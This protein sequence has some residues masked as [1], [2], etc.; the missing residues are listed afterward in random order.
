[1]R[2]FEK[3]IVFLLLLSVSCVSTRNSSKNQ[4]KFSITLSSCYENFNIKLQFN[5]YEPY[6]LINVVS[7]ESLGISNT[8]LEYH[9]NSKKTYLV[10]T[11]NNVKDTLDINLDQRFNLKVRLLEDGTDF[12]NHFSVNT[13]KGKI[14]FLD[15]CVTDAKNFFNLMQYRRPVLLD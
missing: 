8:F 3:I 6:T 7:N 9:E 13:R 10:V 15:A 5:D 12:K 1:M 11:Q 14:I 2:F 4:A